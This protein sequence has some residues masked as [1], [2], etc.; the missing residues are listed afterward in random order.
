MKRR[1]YTMPYSILLLPASLIGAFP[2]S[3]PSLL[4]HCPSRSHP[5]HLFSLLRLWFAMVP[6]I[7]KLSPNVVLLSKASNPHNNPLFFLYLSHS[8]S[9]CRLPFPISSLHFSPFSFFYG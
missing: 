2:S 6:S 9:S 3:F 7:R 1:L 8:P 4:S 5:S